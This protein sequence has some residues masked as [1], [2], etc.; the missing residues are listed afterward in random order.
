MTDIRIRPADLAR[1]LPDTH[2]LMIQLRPALADLDDYVARVRRQAQN[3]G[4]LVTVLEAGLASGAARIVAVAGY[5][6]GEML[7]RGRFLYVDDLVTD[8]AERS[9]GYGE[10]LLD[11]LIQ[12]ARAAGCDEFCLDSGVQRFAAH[13][14]YLRK[15]LDITAHH[16]CLRLK[17]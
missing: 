5:R 3:D 4:Y 12:Q 16:F 2:R 10:A 6:F 1:D 13:R 9:R 8:A 17:G 11:W 14:F 7:H 15:R